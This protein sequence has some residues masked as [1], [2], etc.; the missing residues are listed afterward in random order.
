M[1]LTIRV[2]EAQ[3]VP[4]LGKV[5]QRL[6]DAVSVTQDIGIVHP[7]RMETVSDL[8]LVGNVICLL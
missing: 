4:E 5:T 8:P 2:V 6:Q 3:P 1:G 7:T